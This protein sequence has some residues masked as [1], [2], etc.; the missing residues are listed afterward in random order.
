MTVRYFEVN[1]CSMSQ[2]ERQ[3]T[4]R[5]RRKHRGHIYVHML[6]NYLY[7]YIHVGLPIFGRTVKHNLLTAEIHY[8]FN[9]YN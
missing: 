2:D 4:E 1:Q 8:M 6:I 3:M 9:Y 5:A 7:T